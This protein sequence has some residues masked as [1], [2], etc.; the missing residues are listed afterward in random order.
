MG[1]FSIYIKFYKKIK[2]KSKGGESSI[3]IKC[4]VKLKKSQRGKQ[5]Q[6]LDRNQMK[7]KSQSFQVHVFE[8][9]F[10]VVKQLCGLDA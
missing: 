10:Y 5:V 8:L 3:F 2:N 9:L 4:C 7:Y 1:N 6:H